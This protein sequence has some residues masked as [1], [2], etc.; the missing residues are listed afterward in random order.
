MRGNPKSQVYKNRCKKPKIELI[1]DAPSR[2]KKHLEKCEN[3]YIEKYAEKYKELLLNKRCNPKAKKAIEYKVNIENEE[4]LRERIA[5]LDK[6]IV[7]R[8]DVEN[9]MLYYD[10]IIEGT[11][12]AT[13]TRYNNKERDTALEQISKKKQKLIK[14]LTINFE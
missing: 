10:T 6:R 13:K 1:I 8:D 5:K 2:D 7:I 12:H 9:R 14:E 11:R 4:Q 3:G